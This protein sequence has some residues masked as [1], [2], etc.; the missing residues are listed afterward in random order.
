MDMCCSVVLSLSLHCILQ[1]SFFLLGFIK[2]N[3]NALTL[4]DDGDDKPASPVRRQLFLDRLEHP[5]GDDDPRFADDDL[6]LA[7]VGDDKPWNAAGPLK[8]KRKLATK[9]EV[10]AKRE[11][12]TYTSRG[13]DLKTNLAA[14]HTLIRKSQLGRYL[15]LAANIKQLQKS[16]NRTRYREDKPLSACYRKTLFCVMLASNPGLPISQ[17]CKTIPLVVSAVLEGYGIL[18]GCDLSS[19][20][21]SFAS[22]GTLRNF[23]YETAADCT[24][25]LGHKLQTVSVHLACDKGTKK[26]LEHLVKY[27]SFYCLI[28]RRV[29]VHIIDIDASGGTTAAVAKSIKAS[30]AKFPPFKLQG[31]TTDSG[32]GGVLDKLGDDLDLVGLCHPNYKVAAC[33][34]HLLQLCLANAVKEAIGE[35]GVDQRNATQMC[36][37][38]YYLQKDLGM[39]DWHVFVNEAHD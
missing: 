11:V 14:S 21:T 7:D 17:A 24:Y 2:D 3:L 5:D 15:D 26:G 20:V 37:S 13:I 4:F 31:Q 28:Q 19:Y 18:G 30:F 12:H 39:K 23:M 6:Y 22:E 1:Y 38:L 8:K 9:E 33:C 29:M 27:V 35:G 36:Y 34:I 25:A 32:G 10:L 16:L